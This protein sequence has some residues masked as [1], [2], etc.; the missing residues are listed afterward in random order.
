MERKIIFNHT[1]ENIKMKKLTTIMI[2]II[3]MIMITALPFNKANAETDPSFKD[4]EKHW[5]K[6]SIIEAA[7]K[8]YV[9]GYPGGTFRPD[10][11]V[12][13]DEFITMMIRSLTAKQ[14]NGKVTWSFEYF[15]KLSYPMQSSL[16]E[17]T[18]YFD[19]NNVKSSTNYWADPYLDQAQRMSFFKRVDSAWG[20]KY[21]VPLT[22]EKAAYL[23]MG[24][25]AWSEHHE[26]EMLADLAWND[27]KDKA[28]VVYTNQVIE[29]YIKG[30]VSGYP[31]KTFRPKGYITRAEA[32]AL[33]GRIVDNSKRT[34]HIPDLTGKNYTSIDMPNGDTKYYVFPNAE[35]NK[36]FDALDKVNGTAPA[37]SYVEDARVMKTYYNSKEDYDKM[38]YENYRGI[39]DFQ[40]VVMNV[41]LGTSDIDFGISIDTKYSL[42]G[43]EKIYD[44]FVNMMFE[45]KADQFNKIFMQKLKDRKNGTFKRVQLVINNRDVDIT[46]V[47]YNGI[48]AYISTKLLK[49]K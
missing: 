33:I 32:V 27:I 6:D 14:P 36:L 43:Y 12:N 25:L 5:A 47:G 29:A 44:T 46:T 15:D 7:K 41:G 30:I 24:L 3:I 38:T 31:N 4:I 23:V 11:R 13:V 40:P 19:P 39:Y 21:N 22:R 45:S 8:G 17:T 37:S 2:A 42:A 18:P 35:F 1:K 26:N 34:P 28:D 10:N 20:G 9:A 16:V 48:A 49:T